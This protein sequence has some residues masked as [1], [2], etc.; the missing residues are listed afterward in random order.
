MNILS[1]PSASMRCP[2]WSSESLTICRR[3]KKT[4]HN[5]VAEA[6]LAE[7]R[8]WQDLNCFQRMPRRDSTNKVDGA[9]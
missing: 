9:W 4:C 6:K 7:F 5:D 3:W 2:P 1:S 8:G